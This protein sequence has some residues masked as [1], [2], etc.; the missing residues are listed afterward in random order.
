VH[1]HPRGQRDRPRPDRPGEPV[2]LS[3][4]SQCSG[5]GSETQG[6]ATPGTEVSVHRT[7]SSTRLEPRFLSAGPEV[8]QPWNRGSCPPDPRFH[9]PGTEVPVHRTRGSTPLEPKFLSTGPEV[10]HPWNLSSCP[11][12]PRFHT[13]GTEV[14]AIASLSMRRGACHE[15]AMIIAGATPRLAD[16]LATQQTQ[17]CREPFCLRRE[18]A[19][20]FG[21]PPGE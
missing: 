13:P 12:D 5:T 3:L 11:P 17:W 8:P 10:P 21:R 9:T 15:S 2:P 4:T 7:R 1:P 14:L 16:A 18:L 19:H 6:S 20:S